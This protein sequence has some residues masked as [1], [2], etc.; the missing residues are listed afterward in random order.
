MILCFVVPLFMDVRTWRWSSESNRTMKLE[1][2]IL[3]ICNIKCQV[4]VIGKQ[5]GTKNFEQCWKGS[6]VLR[7]LTLEIYIFTLDVEKVTL[8]A[9]KVT[10]KVLKVTL[11]IYIKLP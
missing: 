2:N 7:K 1:N 9:Y 8:I 11:E 3:N 10:L 4:F 6:V 5:N